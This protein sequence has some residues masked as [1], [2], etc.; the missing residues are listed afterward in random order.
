MSDK[1]DNPCWSEEVH[2]DYHPPEG[3]FTEK[4]PQVVK[5]L[6]EGADSDPTL[7]LHRLIFY[8][9][10]AGEKLHNVEELDKAKTK[11][12]ALIK[13]KDAKEGKEL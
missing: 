12:E 10:R 7:A 8:M 5:T 9:N 4:A 11:L 13:E 3:T 6:M 2:T 1:K